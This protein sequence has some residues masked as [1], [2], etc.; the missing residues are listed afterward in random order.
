[1]A[2]A[3]SQLAGERPSVPSTEVQNSTNILGAQADVAGA[4]AAVATAERDRD[5]AEAQVLQQEAANARAQSDLERYTILAV[6]QEISKIDF[7]QSDSN[8]KQQAANLQAVQAALLAAARTVD[9]RKAQ[10]DQARSKLVQNEQNAA[11]QLSIRHASVDQQRAN[12]QTA[13]AQLEQAQLNLNYAKIVAPVSGV[14][15]KRFA[16]VGARVNAGQQLLTISEIGYLWVTAN[17]KETQ[18]LHMHPG[19]HA[20]IHVDSLD[21]D[22]TGSV[23]SIGGAT[24][25]IASTLPPENAT[26][27]YVKVVQR[28]PVR[29]TLDPNQDGLDMLRPGMSV[30][31]NVHVE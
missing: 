10:L 9:Q 2:Q 19:Q 18:L 23:D 27:N 11:P 20:S 8:A 3:R 28:I 15:M 24:G 12:L 29:I 16:Q 22:F 13:E 4:Q 14:V 1:L 21:R 25:S 26:G 17:F 7:D 6:K 5:Q 31:P 30:E